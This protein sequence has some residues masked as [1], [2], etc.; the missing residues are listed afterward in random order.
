MIKLW[1]HLDNL[2]MVKSWFIDLSMSL[3]DLA[4]NALYFSNNIIV[5]VKVSLDCLLNIRC[6][7]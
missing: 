7:L 2:K 4:I 6:K 1:T 3:H 5:F